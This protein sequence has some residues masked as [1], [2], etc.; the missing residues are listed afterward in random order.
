MGR[1]PDRKPRSLA[2]PALDRD[3]AAMKLDHHPDEV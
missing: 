3:I 2:L 1:Q